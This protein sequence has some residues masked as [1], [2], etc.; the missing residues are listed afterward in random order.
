[1]RAAERPVAEAARAQRAAVADAVFQD[2]PRERQLVAVLP[3]DL[4]HLAVVS[5]F[6]LVNSEQWHR[7]TSSIIR[8]GSMKVRDQAVANV[9]VV[10]SGE[11]G[12]VQ[13]QVAVEAPVEVRLNGVPFSVIMRTPGEDHDLALGFLFG[14]GLIEGR[15]DVERVDVMDTGDVVNVVFVR[16]KGDAVAAALAERRQVTMNSSCGMCGRRTLESLK[17][18]SARPP[19]DWTISRSVIQELPD[20]LRD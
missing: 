2:S 11:T 20:R 16:S 5:W 4:D 6:L 13:D 17:V 15:N 9:D 12:S 14:E 1:M 18:D 3:G 7:V 19:T 10:R 8:P